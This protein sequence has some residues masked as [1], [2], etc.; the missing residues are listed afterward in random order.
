MARSLMEFFY[1]E[2]TQFQMSK[3]ANSKEVNLVAKA[4]NKLTGVSQ[5]GRSTRNED[6]D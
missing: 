1:L 3:W 4:E 5:E 2:L 6:A